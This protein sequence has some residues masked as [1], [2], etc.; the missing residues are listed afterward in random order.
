MRG[1]PFSAHTLVAQLS[2]RA[3][4]RRRMISL[5]LSFIHHGLSYLRT[6]EYPQKAIERTD[7]YLGSGILKL[8]PCTFS[9]ECNQT[10]SLADSL[11]GLNGNMSSRVTSRSPEGQP[12]RAGGMKGLGDFIPYTSGIVCE[13]QPPLRGPSYSSFTAAQ[14]TAA[15]FHT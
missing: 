3:G 13:P 4:R 6:N 1:E 11:P 14:A 8:F 15:G 5:R 7:L 9:E 10:S 2:T 12:S